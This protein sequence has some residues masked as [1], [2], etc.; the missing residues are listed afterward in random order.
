MVF[1]ELVSAA[2][3]PGG[4]T[5]VLTLQYGPAVGIA[6]SGINALSAKVAALTARVEALEAR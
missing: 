6:F 2:P 5:P 3:M 4:D 1:P